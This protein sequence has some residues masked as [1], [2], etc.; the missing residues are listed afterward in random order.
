MRVQSQENSKI[1]GRAKTCALGELADRTGLTKGYLSRIENSKNP[2]PISTLEESQNA[3]GADITDLF[4]QTRGYP[5][6]IKS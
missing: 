2:P 1:L 3:L 4:C 5:K 6:R